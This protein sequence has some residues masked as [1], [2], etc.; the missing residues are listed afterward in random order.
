VNFTHVDLS[1]AKYIKGHGVSFLNYASF[2]GEIGSLR[3]FIKS[4]PFSL[5]SI[6]LSP[7]YCKKKFNWQKENDK[8]RRR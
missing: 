6:C 3:M 7:F 4:R 2:D 5:G 1:Y 8:D